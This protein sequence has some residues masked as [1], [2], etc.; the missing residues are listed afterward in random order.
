MK[1]QTILVCISVTTLL[2]LSG[3]VSAAD[4]DC[5]FDKECELE[6]SMRKEGNDGLVLT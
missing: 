6:R 2:F 4:V 1:A 3:L 5:F